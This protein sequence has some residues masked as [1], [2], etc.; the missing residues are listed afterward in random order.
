M[1]KFL[2]TVF[3]I[4]AVLVIGTV[5]SCFAIDVNEFK[6][7]PDRYIYY[8]GAGT[9]TGMYIDKESIN[10]HQY[11]PPYYI[12][13]FK[14]LSYFNNGMYGYRHHESV[15]YRKNIERYFYNYDTKAMYREKYDANHQ[16]Y[17]EYVDPALV[18]TCESL[19]KHQEIGMGEIAFYLA[20]NMGF[21]DS[22]VDYAT[23]KYVSKYLK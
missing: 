15:S 10:V 8:G 9:G 6:A 17:W 19:G 1:K 7:N 14:T 4:C 12:I 5:S 22:P 3:S 11:N 20:Y 16:P 13:A 2:M 18:N 23:K 21:Y